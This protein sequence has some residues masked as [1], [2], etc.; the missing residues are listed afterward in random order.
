M[1]NENEKHKYTDEE[2]AQF[3]REMEQADREENKREIEESKLKILRKLVEETE[4]EHKDY[5]FI[6]FETLPKEIQVQLKDYAEKVKKGIQENYE[7]LA[8]SMINDATAEIQSQID[9]QQKK[10][11]EYLAN[12][13]KFIDI[14]LKGTD[15]NIYKDF[16]SILGAMHNDPTH[17]AEWELVLYNT[18]DGVQMLKG[19]HT[20]QKES[21]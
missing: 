12:A 14:S 17:N 20:K 1:N 21:D 4:N 9:E 13:L 2:R 19:N 3:K 6:P 10:I 8:Q 7:K 11:D 16:L 15:A 5:S 18:K